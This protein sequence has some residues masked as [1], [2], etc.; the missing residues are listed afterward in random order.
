MQ[1]VF[2]WNNAGVLS[3]DEPVLTAA[4]PSNA[5]ESPGGSQFQ[6]LVLFRGE[7]AAASPEP[8]CWRPKWLGCL[9]VCIPARHPG[10][11]LAAAARELGLR[12]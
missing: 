2:K 12:G 3:F 11:Y 1:Q 8:H 7:R 10:R 4:G 9:C 5:R 6:Q